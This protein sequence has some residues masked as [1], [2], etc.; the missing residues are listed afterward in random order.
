MIKHEED[1][2]M[3]EESSVNTPSMF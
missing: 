3:N 1:V 2:D